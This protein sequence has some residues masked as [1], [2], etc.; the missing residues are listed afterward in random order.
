MC[1]G[2][3]ADVLVEVPLTPGRET[4]QRIDVLHGVRMRLRPGLAPAPPVVIAGHRVDVVEALADA[5]R[6]ESIHPVRPSAAKATPTH[7][8]CRIDF[9]ALPRSVVPTD[10]IIASFSHVL[11]PFVDSEATMTSAAQRI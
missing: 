9:F 11:V 1:A 4:V 3:R 6:T 10:V 2:I 8:L 5:G 7:R